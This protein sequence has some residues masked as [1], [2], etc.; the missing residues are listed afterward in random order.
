MSFQN[1]AG[2][3]IL[4][5]IYGYRATSVEDPLLELVQVGLNGFI[6]AVIPANFL[7]NCF[8]F[9]EM[10]PSWFPEAG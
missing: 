1:F 4:S 3:R 6:Q 10:I 7:V 8:P 2:S 9:L 5:A